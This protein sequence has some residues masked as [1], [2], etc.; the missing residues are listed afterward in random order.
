MNL[1]YILADSAKLSCYFVKKNAPRILTITS[2]V[3]AVGACVGTGI[4][5]WNSKE[6]IEL[7]NSDI[8]D[9]HMQLKDSKSDPD[10]KHKLHKKVAKKY[11]E[12]AGTV[13]KHYSIPAIFLVASVASGIASNS[14][15]Q[16][17]IAALGAS[18][19]LLKEVYD[20]YRAEVVEKYG[21]EADEAIAYGYSKEQ[22]EIKD[23]KGKKKKVTKETCDIYKT[24]HNNPCAI[25]LGDGIECNFTNDYWSNLG[26]L[27]SAISFCTYDV[28]AGKIVTAYDFYSRLGVK[29]SKEQIKTWTS[30]RFS[31][32]SIA[33]RRD[34][35]E[36]SLASMHGLTPEEREERRNA[37]NKIDIG[38]NDKINSRWKEQMEPTLWI[39]PDVVPM[40]YEDTYIYDQMKN[41]FQLIEF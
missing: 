13:A 21:K 26:L 27:N 39:I 9:L 16:A 5:T 17:R 36:K 38:L 41:D 14:I 8:H 4:A 6:V 28:M 31:R 11:A 40:D 20:K 7:H 10:K 22:I 3:T 33:L 12:T 25:L 19:A 1:G 15:S 35:C 37:A 2:A 34:L 32:D 29:A 18:Y 30:Y 24:L 23:E